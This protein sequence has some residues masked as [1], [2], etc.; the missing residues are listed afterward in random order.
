MEYGVFRAGL[1]SVGGLI[2][3]NF[4][5]LS[6]SHFTDY[7]QS[8]F[9]TR[10]SDNPQ[11]KVKE[12]AAYVYFMDFIKECESMTLSSF[13]HKH[14]NLHK[15]FPC[16]SSVEIVNFMTNYHL[17]DCLLLYIKNLTRSSCINQAHIISS[18]MLHARRM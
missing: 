1:F 5:Q 6:K 9:E 3:L 18:C 7:F 13:I 12:E 2:I 15:L 17:S 14:C 10:F 16:I 11:T 8:L 4:L